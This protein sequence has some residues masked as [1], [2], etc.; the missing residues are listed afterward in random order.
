[1]NAV[2]NETVN[3]VEIDEGL[4]GET[5][6]LYIFL[7]AI[8]AGLVFLAQHYL[9]SMNVCTLIYFYAKCVTPIFNLL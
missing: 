8:V 1:M 2:F 6:F 5:I 3:I 4:D 7:A 9:L